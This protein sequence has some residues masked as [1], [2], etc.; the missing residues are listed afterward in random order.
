MFGLGSARCKVNLMMPRLHCGI[1]GTLF[2]F[3]F[4]EVD[5]RKRNGSGCQVAML[6][7]MLA[8]P[9]GQGRGL[10]PRRRVAVGAELARQ[11]GARGAAPAAAPAAAR[12]YIERVSHAYNCR[13]TPQTSFRSSMSA[14][15]RTKQIETNFIAR[16]NVSF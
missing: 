11:W 7:V 6:H 13:N 2:S 8:Q 10:L 1:C 4:F 5:L 12:R 14:L 9:Q 15:R 16:K 3:L